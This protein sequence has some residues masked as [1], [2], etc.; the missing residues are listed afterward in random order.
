MLKVSFTESYFCSNTQGW[1][2]EGPRKQ[3][4]A[5]WEKSKSS[6]TMC[7]CQ[8]FLPI[9]DKASPYSKWGFA[10]L[11]TGLFWLLFFAA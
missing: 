5:G 8:Y 9:S 1:E 4:G 10:E 11:G 3:E 7:F 2:N 6:I